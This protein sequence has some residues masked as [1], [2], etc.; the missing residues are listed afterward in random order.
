ME[1]QH[2]CDLSFRNIYMKHQGLTNTAVSW[3]IFEIFMIF[4]N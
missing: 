3:L 4:F 2:L 1:R